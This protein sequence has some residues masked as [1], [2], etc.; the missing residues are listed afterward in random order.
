LS[1]ES[2]QG[3]YFKTLSQK[4]LSQ[5]RPNGVAQGVSPKLNPSTTKKKRKKERK[6]GTRECL[7]RV[8]C[9]K[10]LLGARVGTDASP[11]VTTLRLGTAGLSSALGRVPCIH[12]PST[13]F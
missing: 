11:K 2:I 13:K 10:I 3:K 9:P 4:N 8:V 6:K 5:K 1:F 12:Q 7:E